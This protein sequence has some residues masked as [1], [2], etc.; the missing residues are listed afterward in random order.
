MR[1]RNARPLAWGAGLACVLAAGAALAVG[2]FG[3][4]V[5]LLPQDVRQDLQQRARHWAALAP[6]AQAALRGRLD[7]WD[8]LPVP[9]RARIRVAYAAWQALPA[10]ERMRVHAAAAAYARL[11]PSRQAELRAQFDAL[12]ARERHGW[13]LGPSLGRDYPRLQP[14]LAQV[15]EHEHAALL[16]VLRA[17]TP[18]QRD[19]LATLVQRTPPGERAALRAEL[20][21]TAAVHRDAW[22]WQR[23]DR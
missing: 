1:S 4:A 21:S 2:A 19:M 6:A 7:A 20:A 8:R 12:D 15:P 16:R 14:L 9:E 11:P 5:P 22:L 3:A 13:L 23:L 17:M 10:G 18:V